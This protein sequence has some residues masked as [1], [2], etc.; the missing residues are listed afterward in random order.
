GIFGF[1]FVNLEE[2]LQINDFSSSVGGTITFA[3]RSFARP[4]T[5]YVEDR[6]G[7]FNRFYGGVV[8]LRANW[9][10]G[11]FPLAL[12][13]KLGVGSIQQNDRADGSPTLPRRF[14]AT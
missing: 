2:S 6:F 12:P 10:V 5:T 11:A 8:G 14:F 4:A 9:H 13:R 3:G 1:K 7:T